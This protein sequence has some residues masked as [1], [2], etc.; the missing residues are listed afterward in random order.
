MDEWYFVVKSLIESR[1][2]RERQEQ[3]IKSNFKQFSWNDASAKCL[4][5]IDESCRSRYT[6][7]Y[8]YTNNLYTLSETSHL[9]GLLLGDWSYTEKSGIWSTGYRCSVIMF[10]NFKF[11]RIDT[12]YLKAKFHRNSFGVVQPKV[13][14]NNTCID[15]LKIGRAEG[16]FH[17]VYLDISNMYSLN[18]STLIRIDFV[19]DRLQSLKEEG[20][21][22]DERLLGICLNQVF[23]GSRKS[24]PEVN[25]AISQIGRAKYSINSIVN[26]KI[27]LAQPVWASSFKDL[28]IP[29]N[30]DFL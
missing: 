11:G 3:K 14:V 17:H 15:N 22:K 2:F 19:F 16:N 5:L 30:L 8:A 10:N 18:K 21:S 23:C 13:Y 9:H 24:N 29:V 1:L 4:E 20:K 25:L 12:L 6:P 27:E 28:D 7:T 26:L